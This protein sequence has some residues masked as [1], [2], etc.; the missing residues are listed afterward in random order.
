VAV[1]SSAVP[2][3]ESNYHSHLPSVHTAEYYVGKAAD[4]AGSETFSFSDLQ[5]LGCASLLTHNNLRYLRRAT[6]GWCNCRR[7]PSVETLGIGTSVKTVRG[8]RE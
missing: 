3:A 2:V 5:F 6:A 1:S 7:Q 4:Q 8:N